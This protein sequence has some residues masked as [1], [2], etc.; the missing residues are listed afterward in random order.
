[1]EKTPEVIDSQYQPGSSCGAGSPTSV[2][3]GSSSGQ[4]EE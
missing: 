3:W 4:G 2:L 1:M